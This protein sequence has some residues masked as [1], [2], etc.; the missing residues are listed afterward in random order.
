MHLAD[1]AVNLVSQTR[2]VLGRG[3][4]EHQAVHLREENRSVGY[5]LDRRTVLDLA[6]DIVGC[7]E[8]GIQSHTV[9]QRQIREGRKIVVI[10][11]NVSIVD[12]EIELD[13]GQFQVLS[14]VAF[15]G[16][17]CTDADRRSIKVSRRVVDGRVISMN[18]KHGSEYW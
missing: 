12:D 18:G 8:H 16:A 9:T 1:Y 17:S 10:C 3:R 6:A 5:V 14:E 2:R 13:C 4:V 15:L 7:D 11:S